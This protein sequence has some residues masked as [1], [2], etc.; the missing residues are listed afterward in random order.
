MRKGLYEGRN[1]L[2]NYYTLSPNFRNCE[3]YGG[4][5]VNNNW[6]QERKKGREGRRKE[7]I[8]AHMIFRV[9]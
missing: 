3:V 4:Y 1:I 9:I 7:K 2:F 8:N 6:K 5:S